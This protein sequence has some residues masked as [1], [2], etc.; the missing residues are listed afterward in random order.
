M[1]IPTEDG[2]LW[3][4][5]NN[6]TQAFEVG[7]IRILAERRPDLVP[8]LLAADEGRGWMLQAD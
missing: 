7:V 6:P 1:R 4:K 8:T 5:A 3:F 2:D